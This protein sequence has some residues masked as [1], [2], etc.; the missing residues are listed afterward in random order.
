[1]KL[2]Q[3][4]FELGAVRSADLFHRGGQIEDALPVLLDVGSRQ[5]RDGSG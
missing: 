1:M 5:L 4:A 2:L 3:A